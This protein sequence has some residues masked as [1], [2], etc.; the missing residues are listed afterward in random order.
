MSDGV[1][2]PPCRYKV[3]QLEE[4]LMEKE[5]ADCGAKETLEPL[6]QAAQLLQINKK[7]PADARAICAMCSAL[8]APQVTMATGPNKPLH[9]PNRGAGFSHWVNLRLTFTGVSA[10]SSC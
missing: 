1:V 10:P 6:V 9:S 2:A 5:L 7:T 4:W 8:T 3:W